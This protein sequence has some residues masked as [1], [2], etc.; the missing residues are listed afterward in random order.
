MKRDQRSAV[1][2]IL[3][4]ESLEER[5][6]LS[7]GALDP[8]F[9][10][11]SGIVTTTVGL[12]DKFESP[13]AIAIYDSPGSVNDGKILAVGNAATQL[14]GGF[15]DQDFALV[16]YNVDGTLDNTF[17]SGG[18]VITPI[19]SG[20]DA[21][22]G[23]AI[24]SDGKILVSGLANDDFAL[25]R[26]NANGTLDTTF[27]GKGAKGIITTHISRGSNDVPLDMKLQTDGK[28]LIAG[29]TFPSKGGSGIALVRYNADGSLDKSFDGDGIA[30]LFLPAPVSGFSESTEVAIDSATGK[31]VV[32]TRMADGA[33][34]VVAH[35]NTNGSLDKS[36]GNGVGYVFLY[37]TAVPS[38]VQTSNPSLAIQ[39]DSKILVT[40]T[41][42]DA[43][44]QADIRLVRLTPIGSLDATF[45]GD[46]IVTTH[47]PVTFD[48]P[49]SI[50]IQADGKI[51]VGGVQGVL[52]DP[53]SWGFFLAHYNTDG[54][55]DDG[56]ATD[57]TPLDS[58]GTGGIAVSSGVLVS[59][60]YGVDLALRS[61]G[62]L[63]IAGTSMN[64][65]EWVLASFLDK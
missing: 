12:Y 14:H 43:V 27:G 5:C 16:R 50:V 33:S 25:V 42:S 30:T 46:G 11:G 55:L 35:F 41:T 7:A 34:I 54:S 38:L 20:N 18:K 60:N 3:C 17:G 4:L 29:V 21:A 24:Q 1:R 9:G 19:G 44:S 39:A 65:Y 37:G 62:R 51:V 48:L 15:P 10:G 31:I 59:A 52:L 13:N 8:T 23:V 28:I 6:L 45:D 58:F 40:F 47:L 32:A 63:I 64:D 61:D 26:Y 56:S 53:T 2:T 57:S 49:G 36:F 22:T